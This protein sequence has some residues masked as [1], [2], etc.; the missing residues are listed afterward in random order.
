MLPAR[1]Q[2]H[3]FPCRSRS[4]SFTLSPRSHFRACPCSA[5]RP[6]PRTGEEEVFRC[7]REARSGGLPFSQPQH[8]PTHRT[9]ARPNRQARRRGS[10]RE[11]RR[12]PTGRCRPHHWC[13]ELGPSGGGEWARCRGIARPCVSTA[14]SHGG[15]RG[16][17]WSRWRGQGAGG[18][19]GDGE[20]LAAVSAQREAA[21][22]AGAAPHEREHHAGG[23]S[24]SH[25]PQ[26]K[27]HPL[28]Q[29]PPTSDDS[30]PHIRSPPCTTPVT[31]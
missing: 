8:Y 6:P 27:Q 13:H 3:A 11:R 28:Q 10:W 1:T 12:L 18:N 21:R 2:A 25:S 5:R 23:R 9:Q 22:L 30:L 20:A 15:P 26:H 7:C 16:R 14:S 24:H 4:S 19:R 31:P 29:Q 17:G